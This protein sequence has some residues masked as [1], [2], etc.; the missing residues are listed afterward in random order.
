MGRCLSRNQLIS[1]HGLEKHLLGAC[2]RRCAAR[3]KHAWMALSDSNPPLMLSRFISGR[4]LILAFGT[5]L[6]AACTSCPGERIVISPAEAS[7]IGELVFA[8]ECAGNQDCLTWWNEGEDFASMGIGHFIWYPSGKDGPFAESFPSLLAFMR[9]AGVILPGW[10]GPDTNCPWPTRAAFISAKNEQK[11][12]ELRTLL[13]ETKHIQADFMVERLYS[14]LPKM[15]ATAPS[16]RRSHIRRQFERVAR[17]PM[18]TYALVDY[19]NFKGEGTDPRERYQGCGWGL[20]QVLDAMDGRESGLGAIV[21]FA[22]AA[23]MV[24]ARRVLLAP[25]KRQEQ[26]WLPGWKKRISSYAREGRI[27]HSTVGQSD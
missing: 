6:L 20:L 12:I 2:G 1:W 18:G 24:L 5:A 8:N 3:V 17:S 27:A 19:V 26:R 21:A 23:E 22:A 16:S 9:K 11:M 13:A 4:L 7:R 14:A 25:K 10:M 15:L